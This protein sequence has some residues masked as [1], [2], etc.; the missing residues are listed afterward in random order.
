MSD[1]LPEWDA[2]HYAANTGHHRAFDDAFLADTPIRPHH[3]LVDLGCGSGDFTRVLA[4]LVPEGQVVGVDPHPGF[5]LEAKRRAGANQTF[6]LG[7]AQDLVEALDGDRFDGIVS[8]A[9]LQWAPRADQPRIVAAV[10]RSLVPGGFFRLDM[11]GVGNIRRVVE[12]L[13]TVSTALDGPQMPW[14]F[15]E[16]DWYLEILEGVGFRVEF[17][18]AVA[19]RRP[20]DRESL[21]EWLDSQVFQAY[22][23]DLAPAARS[24]L[25]GEVRERLD[26][27][28]RHDGSYDQTFVRLDA[29]AYRET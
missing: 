6:A 2:A 17:V 3:R 8:R 5:L 25:R 19:Q 18:R 10:H 24:R 4:D 15:A 7:T 12:L 11:S 16:P 23:V 29:L 9:A 13:D 22:E 14:C 21:W 20:F 28:R 26:E 27:L 1:R